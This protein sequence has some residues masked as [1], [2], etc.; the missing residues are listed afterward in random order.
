[1]RLF[2]VT[3]ATLLLFSCDLRL[4][5]EVIYPFQKDDKE[6]ITKPSRIQWAWI[7]TSTREN[8]KE[9]L[10]YEE[11]F[12]GGNDMRLNQSMCVYNNW[13]FCFNHGTS[14]KL[15]DL[16][17]LTEIAVEPLPDKSHHNNA[18]FL[19]VFTQGE[20][21]PLLLLS[22]GNYP[23]NKDRLYVIQVKRNNSVLSFEVVKTV[24]C[25]IPAAQ[26]NGSW[27]ADI[28]NKRLFL[29]SMTKSDWRVT[30]DNYFC[31]YTFDLP[32]L[33]NKEEISLSINDVKDYWEYPYLIHQGGTYYNGYL[34]F[35]VQS[36][37]SINGY[38]TETSK[39]VL[40]INAKTGNVDAIMPLTESME[41]EGICVYN[42]QLYVSFKYGSA[43]QEPNNIV[44]RIMK[45]SLPKEIINNK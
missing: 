4:N 7:N 34:F 30:E 22:Q 16:D 3:I 39:N 12:G 36:L 21:F 9:E 31:I 45:Y 29:Y 8:I 43:E 19:D 35:N 15:L 20:S 38:T 18:Q 6:D 5:D 11:L 44:F 32:D 37:S 1:M 33:I 40:A 2:S 25:S 23:P 14:C 42:N 27:V 10:I 17:S 28:T 26:N 13:A 24:K 41:T